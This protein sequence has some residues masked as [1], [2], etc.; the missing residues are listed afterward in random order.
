MSSPE[1]TEEILVIEDF[2]NHQTIQKLKYFADGEIGIINKEDVKST[3][4][5]LETKKSKGLLSERIY[6]N[7]IDDTATAICESVFGTII[8]QYYGVQIE[9]YETPHIIRYRAGGKYVPHSD[10]DARKDD[11]SGWYRNVERD[12]SAIIYFNE[13]F[14]GGQLFFPNQ[15]YRITPKPGMLVCFP[16]DH[17]FIHTA[18]PTISGI[19]YAFVT[20]AVAIGTE[21]IFAK[22]RGEI[23][24]LNRD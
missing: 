24:Y 7:K 13:G 22:P 21:R 5:A 10:A 3:N 4:G 12:F 6:T 14:E 19:R 20:W 23:V 1:T 8:P 17:R 15:D 2:L 18:E 9:W 16:S 11:Q